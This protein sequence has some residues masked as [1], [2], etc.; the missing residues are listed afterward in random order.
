MSTFM[1]IEANNAISSA[2]NGLKQSSRQMQIAARDTASSAV[3][4]AGS[5]GASSDTSNSR[6]DYVRALKDTV[7][8]SEFDRPV[9]LEGAFVSAL[10]SGVTYTANARVVQAANENLGTMLDIYV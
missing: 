3:S 2:I 9:G 1:A 4:G 10:E 6:L 7:T 8:L 5:A